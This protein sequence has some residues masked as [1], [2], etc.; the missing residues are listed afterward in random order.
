MIEKP[1]YEDLEIA[2]YFEDGYVL[3]REKGGFEGFYW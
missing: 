1:Q 3:N 2:S